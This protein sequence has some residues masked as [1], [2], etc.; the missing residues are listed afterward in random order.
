MRWA[1]VIVAM[2]LLTAVVWASLFVLDPQAFSGHMGAHM[3]LVAIIAP[4]AAC[5]VSGTWLDPTASWHPG[6]ALLLSFVE[7]AVVWVWHV[8]LMRDLAEVSIG[9]RLL[10]LAAFLV[11][12][13]LLWLACLGRGRKGEVA[14]GGA[15][16]LLLTSMHMTLLGV[17]LTMAPRPLYGSADVTCLGLLMT[18]SQDQQ[19]GGIVMLLMGAII[20]LAGGVGLVAKLVRTPDVRPG[21]GQGL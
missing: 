10:E 13:S 14:L 5:A 17:L 20:Y 7:F 3:V 6:S 12:G 19:L 8:P 9:M 16:A 11:A 4:L 1:S 21:K 15:V 2:A 18:A